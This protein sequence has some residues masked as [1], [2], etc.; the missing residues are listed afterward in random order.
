MV[1][2]NGTSNK[3]VPYYNESV[4]VQAFSG[5]SAQKMRM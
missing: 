3:S 2:I 1:A 4:N 5:E